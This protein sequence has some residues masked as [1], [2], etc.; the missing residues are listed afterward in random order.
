MRLRAAGEDAG[1]DT[2]PRGMLNELYSSGV[3]AEQ[4][5]RE[6]ERLYQLRHVI[7]HGFAAPASEAGMVQFLNRTARR[8]LAE[9]QRAKQPA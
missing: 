1:W 6:L 3:F 5:F 2:M 4:E 8:L 7:V 9:S